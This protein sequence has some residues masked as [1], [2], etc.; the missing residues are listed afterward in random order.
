[1][2][3]PKITKERKILR[4]EITKAFPGAKPKEIFD[5][6]VN[7]QAPV[8]TFRTVAEYCEKPEIDTDHLADIFAPYG[9]NDPFISLSQWTEFLNDDFADYENGIKYGEKLTEKQNFILLKFMGIL[10]TKF[11]ASMASRWNS[12]LARNPP[13]ASN[14]ELRVSAL[15][16]I[17][18]DTNLPF[19]PAEF[20]DAIF[21]FYDEKLETL[22]FDQFSQLFAAY[23]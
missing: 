7:E 22:T 13:N 19:E 18:H 14:T 15:C 6:V 9:V 8:I 4:V 2:F 23:P 12:A 11:G 1:M 20:V 5:K 21:A 17:F 16:R 10:R 3:T